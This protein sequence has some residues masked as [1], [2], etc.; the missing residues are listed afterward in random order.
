VVR[1]CVLCVWEDFGKNEGR[2]KQRD[3]LIAKP[4]WAVSDKVTGS[5]RES[6]GGAAGVIEV[7]NSEDTGTRD[8]TASSVSNRYC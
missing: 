8:D 7:G 5:R 3:L 2:V 1:A 6:D 4:D